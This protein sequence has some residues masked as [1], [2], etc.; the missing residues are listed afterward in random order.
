MKKTTDLPYLTYEMLR[1]LLEGTDPRLMQSYWSENLSIVIGSPIA[2]LSQV[3]HTPFRFD[4]M[5]FFLVERG[6]A[7]VTVNLQPLHMKAGSIVFVSGGSIAQIE[8]LVEGTRGCGLS[9]TNELLALAFD[10]RLPA[11]LRRPQLAFTLSATE[12]DQHFM[13]S[14]FS[15]IWDSVHDG[16]TAPQV[17]LRLVSAMMAYADSCHQRLQQQTTEARSHEEQ[18]FDRFIALVNEHGT[19]HHQLPFYAD[20][21]A[22]TPRYLG[23][24]IK[25]VSGVTAKEWIDREIITAIKVELRHTDKSLTEIADQM[26]FPNQ[27]FFSKYFK[28]LTGMTPMQYKKG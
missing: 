4:E 20:R 2:A 11:I 14:L 6:E 8:K 25:S 26:H 7:H 13:R 9:C 28:R 12:K 3:A 10:G 24:V 19:T 22:L 23:A 1:D 15:L 5:R 27:S 16:E 17:T 18:I 21:L